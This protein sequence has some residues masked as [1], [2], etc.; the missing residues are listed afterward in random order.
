M[1]LK[2]SFIMTN[3]GAKIIGNAVSSLV[4][5][6]AVMSAISNNIANVNTPG[7]S[8]RD[9]QLATRQSEGTS[10]SLSVGSG[11]Q[12]ASIIRKADEFID[13]LLRETSGDKGRY[14]TENEVLDRLQSLFNISGDIPNIGSTMTKFFTAANDLAANPSSIELR[15]NF[16]ERATDV[17]NTIKTTYG[18][19][20]NLQDELDSRISSE[21]EAVN[22]LTAQIAS[23]NESIISKESQG[24]E[25]ADE[26]DTRAQLLSALAAKISYN[27]TENSDGSVSIS[28]SNGFT[29]VQGTTSRNLEATQTPSTNSS[30]PPSLSGGLLHYIVY[31]YDTSSGGQSHLDL[32]QI[33]KEGSGE[34][35]GILRMR[36]YNDVTNTSAFQA[37]GPLVEMASK[38]EAMTR[39]L[40]TSVNLA[41]LGPNRDSTALTYQSS[42]GDLNGN[43]PSTFGLFDFEYSG[44]KDTDVDGVPE[45]TDLT[46]IG[47]ANYSSLLRLTISDPVEVAAARDSSGGPPAAASY[48]AGDGRNMLGIAALRTTTY[49]FSQGSTSFSG[50]FDGIYQDSVTRVSNLKASAANNESVS[51]ANQ[52]AAENRRD[53][54]S[55]V[56]LDEEFPN[57]LRTQSA[58]QAAARVLKAGQEILDEIIRLI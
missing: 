10:G 28:L 40:L 43:N 57:L 18:A 45:S 14:S 1:P 56:S 36:G 9:A 2:G 16:I 34:L 53:S 12:V 44:A 15:R 25:A 27:T 47:L 55:G 4:A 8:R 41:Y 38:V 51:S 52:T 31:D 22:T 46:T 54:I 20:S 39:V 32:T 17:V 30:Y 49:T 24:G 58:Y 23:I 11:V 29:L 3:F 50:T 33:I 26:R 35:A 5:Q 48:A 13:K 7:Y 19:I 37:D 6:Q 42:A 21:I